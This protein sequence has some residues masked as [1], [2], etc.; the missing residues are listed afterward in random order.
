MAHEIESNKAFFVSKPAWHGLGTIL[1][2]APTIEEAWTIAYPHTLFKMDLEAFTINDAGERVTLP[3]VNSKVIIRDDGTEF[4]T[5]GNDFE[6]VQPIEI[7]EHFRP[8]LDTG[9]VKLEAGGSLRG[10]SQ[11]WALAKINGADCDI[12]PGDQVKS[13]FLMYTGFDGSL[14]IGMSQTNTRVVCANTLAAAIGS[15]IDHKFKHTKNVRTRMSGA[16]EQVKSALADFHKDAEAYKYLAQKKMTETQ[17]EVYIAKTLLN[18]TEFEGY[19]HDT[20]SRER[21]SEKKVTIVH[22]VLELLDTQ[23][24]LE[25]I[26]AMRG[27]AWQA[28]N[29][30]SEYVTHNYGRTTDSRLNAQWFGESAKLN[31]RALELALAM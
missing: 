4:N 24:G 17:Q 25:Y 16:I 26:P 20:L 7:L 22:N 19:M 5:V 2:D 28:Y 18:D 15:G 3:L 30:V 23:R 29:A 11:M 31:D 1:T 9:H 6:L 12:L 21:I 14:R 8:L 10:G 13:Y 27:T